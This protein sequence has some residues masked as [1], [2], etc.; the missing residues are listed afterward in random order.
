[1]GTFHDNMG[2]LHGIT[3]VVATSDNM[4]YIG[5]CHEERPEGML[6]LDVAEHTEGADGKSNADVIAA[7]AKWGHWP[8]HKRLLV[9]QNRIQSVQRLGGL[10]NA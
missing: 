1:M 8:V 5:R 2:D 4:V 10:R 6:M 9:E 3:V 7:A